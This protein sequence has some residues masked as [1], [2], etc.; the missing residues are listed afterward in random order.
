MRKLLPSVVLVLLACVGCG[1]EPTVF[2]DV[3][4]AVPVDDGY[5]DTNVPETSDDTSAGE[6]TRVDSEPTE[7]DTATESGDAEV[8][9]TATDTFTP[10]ALVPDTF[11]PDT[12]VPDTFVPDTRVDVAPDAAVVCST[13]ACTADSQCALVGCG[14]C[15][16]SGK[17]GN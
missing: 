11:A 13:V 10:D 2:E 3:D 16:G 7:E 17:C 12:F 1:D 9:S 8:D 5:V 14:R 6:D 4:S 15:L